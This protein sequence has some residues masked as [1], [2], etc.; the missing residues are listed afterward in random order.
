VA[1][2]GIN[3]VKKKPHKH[4]SMGLCRKQQVWGVG[5]E[6]LI[7]NIQTSV[8]GIQPGRA[9]SPPANLHPVPD[10]HYATYLLDGT[11]RTF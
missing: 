2:Q 4:V 8:S 10:I 1:L 7:I 9:L 5:R 11:V 6:L 3:V